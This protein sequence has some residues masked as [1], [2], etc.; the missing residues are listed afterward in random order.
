[1]KTKNLSVLLGLVTILLG[2]LVFLLVSLYSKFS[3]TD[4]EQTPIGRVAVTTT[5]KT[6]SV[7]PPAQPTERAILPQTAAVKKDVVAENL[8][9]YLHSIADIREGQRQ[10]LDQEKFTN[11]SLPEEI[12]SPSSQPVAQEKWKRISCDELSLPQHNYED[13][14]CKSKNNQTCAFFANGLPFFCQE[15]TQEGRTSYQTNLWGSSVTRT[16]YD[17]DGKILSLFYF[18]YNVLRREESYDYEQDLI[19]RI[20]WEDQQIRLYQTNT[21][22]RTLNKFYLTPDK[23]YVQYPDGNDMGEITGSWTKDGNKIYLEGTFLYELP[24][25]NTAPDLCQL[26]HGA[27]SANDSTK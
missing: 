24:I 22:G 18:A 14:F 4:T 8:R 17:K 5:A 25:Q 11:F 26:F 19:T 16:Q 6:I 7:P 10:A 21:K 27:C 9:P 2:A 3:R 15:I 20:W 12:P 1:M 23:P 13:L